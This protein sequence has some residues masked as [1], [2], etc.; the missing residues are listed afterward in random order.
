MCNLRAH[1]ALCIR[2]FQ[3][4]GYSAAFTA[5]MWDVVKHLEEHDPDVTLLRECDML[6]AACPHRKNGICESTEKVHRFDEKLL[7]LCGLPTGAQIRWSVLK[8]IVDAKIL[9]PGRL[10]SVCGDCQWHEL[11]ASSEPCR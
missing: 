7:A 9:A 10:S 1:H 11:C 3:G 4:K 8:C 2:F 5:Q 6:C